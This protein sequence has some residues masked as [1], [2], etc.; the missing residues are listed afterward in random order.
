[1]IRLSDQHEYGKF[2]IA[3]EKRNCHHIAYLMIAAFQWNNLKQFENYIA[4]CFELYYDD[5]IANTHGYFKFD[6]VGDFLTNLLLILRYSQK[7]KK[8]NNHEFLPDIRHLNVILD[9]SINKNYHK[10]ITDQGHM[11]SCGWKSFLKQLFG[12]ITSAEKEWIWTSNGDDGTH[13]RLQLLFALVSNDNDPLNSTFGLLFK[14]VVNVISFVF[15]RQNDNKNIKSV[16]VNKCDECEE[17]GFDERDEQEVVK[18]IDV[19]VG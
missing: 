6:F 15:Q 11:K 16:F 19:C 5:A 12:Y 10:Y 17:E 9:Y 4:S 2:P 14:E 7:N 1:M 13:K 8:F 18:I 3:Q